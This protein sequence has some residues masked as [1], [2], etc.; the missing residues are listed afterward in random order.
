MKV[1]KRRSG[2]PS[3]SA[4]GGDKIKL[5]LDLGDEPFVPREPEQE[6]DAVGLAP[7]HQV[8]PCKAAVGAQNVPD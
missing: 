8:L 5:G 3:A 1:L 6:V 4:L 2:W 7:G